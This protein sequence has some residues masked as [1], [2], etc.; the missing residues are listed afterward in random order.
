M[1]INAWLNV[2]DWDNMFEDHDANQ[3][4]NDF[5]DV[6]SSTVNKFTPLSRGKRTKFPA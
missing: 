1:N 5:H 4:W 2:L 6:F 3:M